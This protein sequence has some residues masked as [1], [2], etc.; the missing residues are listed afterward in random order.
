MRWLRR[1]MTRL[2]NQE[3]PM[4]FAKAGSG[5]PEI[6]MSLP[7]GFNTRSDFSS[8]SGP[9]LFKTHVVAPQDFLKVVLAV[10]NDYIR[11]KA[12]HRVRVGCAG[13]GSH[14]CS[15]VLRQAGW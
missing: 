9:R 3:A 2:R 10:V 11:T 12:F 7:P 6:E 5:G 15:K 14:N 4:S 13:R 8:T 1:R